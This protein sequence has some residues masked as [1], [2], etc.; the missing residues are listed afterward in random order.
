MWRIH[1]IN[2]VFSFD[3][4]TK[5][6]LKVYN[7]NNSINWIDLQYDCSTRLYRLYTIVIFIVRDKGLLNRKDYYHVTDGFLL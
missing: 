6:K 1:S 5:L 3:L 7:C 2:R 4:T